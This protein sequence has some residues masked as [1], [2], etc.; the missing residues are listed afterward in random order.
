[1][2]DSVRPHRRQPTRLPRPWDSLGKNT[3]VGCHFLLQ[4]LKV[5]SEREVAQSCPTLRDPMD[6]RLPGSS[7][8]G[9]FQARVLEWGAIAFS[10]FNTRGTEI[11]TVTSDIVPFV[12]CLL[13]LALS[14]FSA[15]FPLIDGQ[16]QRHSWHVLLF[17]FLLFLPFSEGYFSVLLFSFSDRYIAFLIEGNERN[18]FSLVTAKKAKKQNK[19]KCTHK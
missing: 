1:M 2:S 3:G 17:S 11:R 15:C 4:C 6:F 19:T 8:H 9:I 10:A 7:I 14:V 5:K 18:S 12:L 16:Y 13:S